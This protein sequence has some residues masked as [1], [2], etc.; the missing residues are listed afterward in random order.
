MLVLMVLRTDLQRQ[1]DYPKF[2]QLIESLLSIDQVEAH[3]KLQ[4][5]QTEFSGD[6]RDQ[7][8]EMKWVER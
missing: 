3:L 7:Y 5:F 6:L 1:K 4:L 2:H 8:F